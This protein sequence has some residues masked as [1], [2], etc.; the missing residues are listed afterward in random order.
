M[1]PKRT[2]TT[3][4]AAPTSKSTHSSKSVSFG[5]D[6]DDVEEFGDEDDFD[7]SE[8]DNIE[9]FDDY[10]DE[11]DDEDGGDDENDAYDDQIASMIDDQSLSMLQSQLAMIEQ[12]D[13][14]IFKETKSAKPADDKKALHVSNQNKLYQNALLSRMRLQQPLTLFQR[15]PPSSM[16]S[17]FTHLKVDAKGEVA[18]KDGKVSTIPDDEVPSQP[19]HKKLCIAAAV[20]AQALGDLLDLERLLAESAGSSSATIAHTID[21]E[22]PHLLTGLTAKA[23]AKY[24]GRDESAPAAKRQKR[25]P[26]DDDLD[27]IEDYLAEA[28][29]NSESARNKIMDKWYKRVQVATGKNELGAGMSLSSMNQPLSV[30]VQQIVD[31]EMDR[32]VQRSRLRR[33]SQRSLGMQRVE[34]VNKGDGD[35]TGN[36][37]ELTQ[38]KQKEARFDNEVYDDNDLY[39]GMLKELSATVMEGEGITGLS[40]SLRAH[41]ANLKKH[42]KLAKNIDM[43]ASKGRKLRFE[44]LPKVANFMVPLVTPEWI[45]ACATSQGAVST[46][47]AMLG[48]AAGQEMLID[49]LLQGLFGQNERQEKGSIGVKAE[50]EEKEE[51]AEADDDEMDEDGDFEEV[52]PNADDTEQLYAGGDDFGD[53]GGDFS[54]FKQ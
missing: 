2:T 4:P 19:I 18:V 46:T 29:D 15:L 1:P 36:D 9:S 17:T 23:R 14:K 8:D 38:Q 16:L 10:Q 20:T 32:F 40:E 26:I 28:W 47:D 44:V 35:E 3:A 27:A 48:V 7:G 53:D 6:S 54:W 22:K 43:R 39:A 34:F 11:D 49:E 12:Q 42:T 50:S 45:A 21:F 5:D 33:V 52:D 51:D 31:I 37:L 24:E 13:T 25:S 41:E 30:Q